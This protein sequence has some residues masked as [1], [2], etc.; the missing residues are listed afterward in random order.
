MANVFVNEGDSDAE[1]KRPN[2]LDVIEERN[3]SLNK[4]FAIQFV[5]CMMDTLVVSNRAGVQLHITS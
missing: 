1:D 3:R 5:S 4:V 2:L